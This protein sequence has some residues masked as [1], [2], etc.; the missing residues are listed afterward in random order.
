MS[1]EYDLCRVIDDIE[2]DYIDF[3]QADIVRGLK[4]NITYYRSKFDN[5]RNHTNC[6][7]SDNMA[8]LWTRLMRLKTEGAVI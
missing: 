4:R 1:E 3:L 7:R 8:T 5:L 6:R 2:E